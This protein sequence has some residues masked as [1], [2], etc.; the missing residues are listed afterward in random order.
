MWKEYLYPPIER[1]ELVKSLRLGFMWRGLQIALVFYSIY[2]YYCDPLQVVHTIEPDAYS[3]A[4]V[5]FDEAWHNASKADEE[6]ILCKEPGAFSWTFL[7]DS[8]THRAYHCSHLEAGESFIMSPESVYVPTYS[9]DRWVEQSSGK[10]DCDRLAECCKRAD[11]FGDFTRLETFFNRDTG[12]RT[13]NGQSVCS[14]IGIRKYFVKGT[15]GAMV[16]VTSVYSGDVP[17]IGLKS[18]TTLP[19]TGN[20]PIYLYKPP[21]KY[22]DS[23]GS[24]RQ[25]IYKPRESQADPS[26]SLVD[27]GV[28]QENIHNAKQRNTKL[29]NKKRADSSASGVRRAA[30]FGYTIL[31]K[32][33]EFVMTLEKMLEHASWTTADE[34]LQDLRPDGFN[35]TS[36]LD[37]YNKDRQPSLSPYT[38]IYPLFRYSGLALNLDIDFQNHAVHRFWGEN[39]IIAIVKLTCSPGTWAFDSRQYVI[40]P[41]NPMNGHSKYVKRE[42]YGVR[43]MINTHGKLGG[44]SMALMLQYIASSMVL[45]S[46][47]G[48]IVSLI[49]LYLL[50]SA[51]LTFYDTSNTELSYVD[52]AFTLGVKAIVTD[53]TFK[54]NAKMVQSKDG[55]TLKGYTKADLKALL[56]EA[57]RESE[58]PVRPE[59]MEAVVEN[60]FR[61]WDPKESGVMTP[62]QLSSLTL[63][64]EDYTMKASSAIHTNEPRGCLDFSRLFL[65]ADN[66]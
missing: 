22:G 44:W 64:A 3:T 41:F 35:S 6:S 57:T 25:Y 11:C 46:V 21:S 55:E 13:L 51:S 27:S 65:K 52:A 17:G 2:C 9:I 54:D 39:R 45:M 34:S 59:Q 53:L 29:K 24:L 42:T 14:C 62:D 5:I 26:S 48:F 18:G 15:P 33:E 63:E 16:A 12:T 43:V 30:G 40:K 23:E 4:K 58:P 19:N 31:E 47:P 7:P 1:Y 20:T 56:V 38:S 32:G 60:L 10:V 66:E 61:C 49:V 28:L 37:A 50:A 8:I 36:M